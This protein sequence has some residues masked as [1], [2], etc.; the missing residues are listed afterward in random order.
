MPCLIKTRSAI[1][2]STK[3]ETRTTEKNKIQNFSAK[4]QNLKLKA[5]SKNVKLQSDK[6]VITQFYFFL[7]TYQMGFF[8]NETR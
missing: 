5:P 3:K 8:L 7:T 2:K 6:T 4:T 1:K